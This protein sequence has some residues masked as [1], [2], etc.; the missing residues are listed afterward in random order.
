MSECM[1]ACVHVC[2]CVNVHALARLASAVHGRLR[3]V[4]PELC[5]FRL[6]EN[7][8]WPTVGRVD[9]VFGDR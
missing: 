8:Y 5:A 6:R 1:Y 2:V 3:V 4:L 7:K 9:N